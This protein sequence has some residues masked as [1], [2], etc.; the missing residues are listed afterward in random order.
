MNLILF[1]DSDITSQSVIKLTGR[2]AK[3]ITSVHRVAIGD[4]VRVGQLGGKI[5]AGI[6]QALSRDHVEIGYELTESPPEKLPVKLIV[7]LPRPKSLKKVLHI[8]TSA[9][10]PEVHICHAYKVDKSYWQ[11][12]VLEE[13]SI[14]EHLILGLEQGVDTVLPSVVFHR[15]FKPFVEDIVPGL[16]DNHRAIIAHPGSEKVCPFNL[17]E[18]AVIAIG[19]EG[20]FIDYEVDKFAEQ[21][22]EKMALGAR[23]LR[24]EFAVASILGRLF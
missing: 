1:D 12:P 14:R 18:P 13:E 4:T 7:A 24:V 5:G 17:Q 2:R 20:G 9:G 6:A 22:F 11:S 10:V 8:V 16:T 23:I 3:H 19:P 15:F 21:G